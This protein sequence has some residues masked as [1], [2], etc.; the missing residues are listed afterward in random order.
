MGTGLAI[1][2]IAWGLVVF[3][4]ALACLLLG[5]SALMTKGVLT[6]TRSDI[7]VD[8]SD[9]MTARV[10]VT[11]NIYPEEEERIRFWEELVR[12]I[13]AQ[14]GIDVVAVTNA[15]PGHETYDGAVTIEGRD[16]GG[17]ATKPLVTGVAVSPSFFKTFRIAPTQ[18]RL[19]DSRD[20]EGTLQVVVINETMAR[21]LFPDE[22]PLGKRIRFELSADGS[23]TR[24]SAWCRMSS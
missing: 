6:A 17:D 21:E 24:S 9:I 23:G 14:P 18:G 11:A 4:V 19:F 8:A 10:G 1:G 16:Y 12:R 5:L 3:E 22:S 20:R 13:E 2:R 15:L 7:G